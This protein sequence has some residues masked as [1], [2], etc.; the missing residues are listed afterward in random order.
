MAL[1]TKVART[2]RTAS[3]NHP[4]FTCSRVNNTPFRST[5]RSAKTRHTR[6]IASPT[7]NCQDTMRGRCR[8]LGLLGMGSIFIPR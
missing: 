7:Q 4:A 1:A 2:L 8:R 6:L 3:T 5:S